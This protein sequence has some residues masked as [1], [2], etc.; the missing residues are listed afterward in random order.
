MLKKLQ[1]YA[2]TVHALA[3]FCAF[4]FVFLDITSFSMN[5]NI[6]ATFFTTEGMIRY[7]VNLALLTMSPFAW[8]LS[9]AL[10]VHSRLE[11]DKSKTRNSQK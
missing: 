4:K 2:R 1:P 8:M 5:V 11:R 9:I 7:L 10:L 3:I 6:R